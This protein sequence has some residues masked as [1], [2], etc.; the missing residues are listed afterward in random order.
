MELQK[1]NK[2][3]A[4]KLQSQSVFSVRGGLPIPLSCFSVLLP[5]GGGGRRECAPTLCSVGS[6]PGKKGR[7][8]Y[9]EK[10]ETLL[11]TGAEEKHFGGSGCDRVNRT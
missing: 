5:G 2:N 8:I 10:L 11:S 6:H 9:V 7:G 1:Q 4:L 3:K